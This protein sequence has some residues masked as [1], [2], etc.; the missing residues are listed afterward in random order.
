MALESGKASQ[1][2]SNPLASSR[3]KIC[4]NSA[5]HVLV[6][7]LSHSCLVVL[8]TA[9]SESQNPLNASTHRKG[10]SSASHSGLGVVNSSSMSSCC[11]SS[12]C[13]CC[14]RD[15]KTSVLFPLLGMQLCLAASTDWHTSPV[16]SSAMHSATADSCMHVYMNQWMGACRLLIVSLTLFLLVLVTNM[17]TGTEKSP[18]ITRPKIA[19][20][21]VLM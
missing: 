7:T 6:V 10:S 14:T 9:P 11:S 3:G 1:D 17:V 4:R 21:V 15:T 2:N 12:T 16:Y 8:C 20:A 5:A 19:R 13:C 18:A